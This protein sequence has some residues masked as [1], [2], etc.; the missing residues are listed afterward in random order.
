MGGVVNQYSGLHVTL[1]MNK[2]TN[3]W[4]SRWAFQV[5]E[6]KR[7]GRRGIWAFGLD[8]REGKMQLNVVPHLNGQDSPRE[9]VYL[10]WFTRFGF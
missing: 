4:M 5:G 2:E 10:I 6:R 7:R 9:D 3:H 1:V 8:Q